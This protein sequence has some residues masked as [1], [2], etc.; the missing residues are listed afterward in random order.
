MT[1]RCL[2]FLQCD[3]GIRVIEK[4]HLFGPDLISLS[5][6]HC[7]S[8]QRYISPSW[9]TPGNEVLHDAVPA[10]AARRVPVAFNDLAPLL[11]VHLN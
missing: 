4:F 7:K 11:K 10:L 8:T 5:R 1:L 6:Q 9:R 3:E 2:D